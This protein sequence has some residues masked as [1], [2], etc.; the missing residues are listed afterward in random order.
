MGSRN[1]R[2]KVLLPGTYIT[3]EF[4]DNFL[5]GFAGCNQYGGGRD[6]GKYFADDDGAF[7]I[8]QMAITVQGCIEPAGVLDQE[9][10][11][12][13]A[14]QR[15]IGYKRQGERLE[16][17]DAGEKS[18]LVYRLDPKLSADPRALLETAW[19]L[20]SVD[21]VAAEDD[22]PM[23]LVFHNDHRVSGHAGCRDY[24]ASFKAEGGDIGLQFMAMIG[25]V[26]PTQDALS[27]EGGFTTT[28]GWADNYRIVEDRLEIVTARGEILVFERIPGPFSGPQGTRWK[29][30][31]MLKEKTISGP[32]DMVVFHGNN[33]IQEDVTIA[34]EGQTVSGL[35]GC[36]SYTGTYQQDGSMITFEGLSAAPCDGTEREVKQQEF[37]NVLSTVSIARM[38]ADRLWLET[39]DGHLL[40]FTEAP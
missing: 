1:A 7:R 31:A 11:Y 32:P 10:T 4:T 36:S 9:R 17:I 15:S 28:L 5:V 26:C 19:R 33:D 8:I 6:S 23:T 14:L 2:R 12:V 24:V 35:A 37:L 39:E 30:I 38:I 21:G 3:L 27:K 29:L 18:I 34:L 16:L 25:P 40:V 13:A 20:A 22:P